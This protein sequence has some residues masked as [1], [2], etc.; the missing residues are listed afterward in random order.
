MGELRFS[1]SF[2]IPKQRPCL[3]G[4]PLLS[5]PEPCQNEAQVCT[6]R[7][8]LP[9]SWSAAQGIGCHGDASSP[10]RSERALPSHTPPSL[11]SMVFSR[12]WYR[13]QGATSARGFTASPSSHFSSPHWLQLTFSINGQGNSL[14][15]QQHSS[16]CCIF[17]SQKVWPMGSVWCTSGPCW[18]RPVPSP[19]GSFH[20]VWRG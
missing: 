8:N 2:Q 18:Q 20:S 4:T 6:C 15:W 9:P 13:R 17:H 16:C 19:K 12:P 14:P 7:L 5:S 3:L 11:E 1:R 10:L